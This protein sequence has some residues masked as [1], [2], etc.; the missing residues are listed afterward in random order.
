MTQKTTPYMFPGYDASLS[1]NLKVTSLF[2]KKNYQYFFPKKSAHWH[3]LKNFPL[4]LASFISYFHFRCSETI[5]IVSAVLFQPY[6]TTQE[7]DPDG[8]VFLSI[9]PFLLSAKLHAEPSRACAQLL[10]HSNRRLIWQ[11]Q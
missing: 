6:K 11:T 7:T 5:Q 1:S 3:S 9:F 4:L 2:I 8:F 10:S